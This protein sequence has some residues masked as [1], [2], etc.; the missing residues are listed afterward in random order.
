M[1]C[2]LLNNFILSEGEF[3]RFLYQIPNQ[4]D[5]INDQEYLETQHEEV[6]DG[7]PNNELLRNHV[8]E[9]FCCQEF[10]GL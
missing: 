3:S 8:F 5:E 2:C 6:E 9:L 10:N 4:D 7:R 1:A